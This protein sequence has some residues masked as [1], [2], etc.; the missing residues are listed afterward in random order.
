MNYGRFAP[1]CFGL[2]IQRGTLFGLLWRHMAAA[3]TTVPRASKD[4]TN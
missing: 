2:G 4:E 3:G 1:G